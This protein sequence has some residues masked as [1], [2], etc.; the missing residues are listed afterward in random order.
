MTLHDDA[1]PDLRQTVTEFV[2]RLQNVEAELSELKERKKELIEEF[3]SRLDMKSFVLAMRVAKAKAAVLQ[4]FEF[5]TIL[6]V[7]EK[8]VAVLP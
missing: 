7:L 4:Q 2:T 6:D 8:D 1:A 3:K 5:E